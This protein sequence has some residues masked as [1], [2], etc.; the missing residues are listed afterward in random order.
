VAE[1]AYREQGQEDVGGRAGEGDERAG[2]SAAKAAAIHRHRTPGD[3]RDQQQNQR[4]AAHVDGGIEGHVAGF[5]G[6]AVAEGDGDDAVGEFVDADAHHD[7]NADG[8]EVS[9]VVLQV[10]QKEVSHHRL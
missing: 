1:S 8:E 2:I 7:G 9:G 6:G 5:N 4:H 10:L 3:S